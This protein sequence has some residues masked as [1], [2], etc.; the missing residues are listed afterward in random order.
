MWTMH[1][2]EPVVTLRNNWTVGFTTHGY[3]GATFVNSYGNRAFTGG[4]QRTIVSTAPR[5]IDASLGFR[6]GFITGYDGRLMRLARDTPVLPLV[7]PFARID[8]QHVGVEVSYTFV[9]MSVGL[10][11]RFSSPR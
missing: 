5:A 3:F 4:L 7:Q 8:F 1:L 2:R 11:Y 9:V 10:S 6:L